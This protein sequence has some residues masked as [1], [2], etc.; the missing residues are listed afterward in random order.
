MVMRIDP[1]TRKAT[2]EPQQFSVAPDERGHS[3]QILRKDQWV[4][5][6]RLIEVAS[7]NGFSK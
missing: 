1:R 4:E 5:N 2:T 7:L 3:L 6:P